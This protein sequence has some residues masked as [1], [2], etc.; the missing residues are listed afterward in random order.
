MLKKYQKQNQPKV[1][2]LKCNTIQIGSFKVT[3]ITYRT[4]PK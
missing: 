3:V 4:C 1:D 2:M